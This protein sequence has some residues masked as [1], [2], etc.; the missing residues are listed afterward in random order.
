MWETCR[1]TILFCFVTV[2]FKPSAA[3][4]K[5]KTCI[6]PQMFWDLIQSLVDGERVIGISL[7]GYSMNFTFL[8]SF[9]SVRVMWVSL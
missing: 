8:L 1:L 9:E 2:L 5:F 7:C 3:F 6:I 4:S